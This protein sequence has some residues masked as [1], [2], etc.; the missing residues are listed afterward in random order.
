VIVGLAADLAFC[1]FAA[2][3]IVFAQVGDWMRR[4]SKG[5]QAAGKGSEPNKP[6]QQ[7]GHAIT[8]KPPSS[9]P[10]A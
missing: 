6:L 8:A 1:F 4:E 2:L 10:P 5:S 9:P 7:T 3:D